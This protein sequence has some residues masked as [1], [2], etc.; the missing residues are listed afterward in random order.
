[1]HSGELM[2]PLCTYT[3]RL[4][5]LFITLPLQDPDDAQYGHDS[6]KKCVDDPG[7]SSHQDMPNHPRFE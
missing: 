5:V 1:M 3:F 6:G 2:T 4:T 7:P